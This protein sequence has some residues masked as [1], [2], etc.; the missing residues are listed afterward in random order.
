VAESDLIRFHH[1]GQCNIAELELQAAMIALDLQLEI[2]EQLFGKDS[3][4][5]TTQTNV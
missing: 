5:Q 3:P 4:H 1:I 2:H